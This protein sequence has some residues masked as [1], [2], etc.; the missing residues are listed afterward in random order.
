MHAHL[1][2][3]NMNSS[4]PRTTA[5]AGDIRGSLSTCVPVPTD[6]PLA[7]GG[8]RLPFGNVLTSLSQSLD[9]FL[10]SD[11]DEKHG[12]FR[13]HREL[14][15][16]SLA[17]PSILLRKTLHCICFQN[18]LN[19]RRRER[20]PSGFSRRFLLISPRGHLDGGCVVGGDRCFFQSPRDHPNPK[21]WNNSKVYMTTNPV[22]THV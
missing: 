21:V 5:P 19:S 11:R 16:T 6:V 1:P 8:P 13:D 10:R 9:E 17:M 15:S 14:L 22:C 3:R 12:I 18:L 7:Y 4:T 20:I 2:Q